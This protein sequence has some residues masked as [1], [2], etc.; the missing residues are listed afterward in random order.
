MNKHFTFDLSEDKLEKE[1]KNVDKLNQQLKNLGIEFSMKPKKGTEEI[2]LKIDVDEKKV[3]GIKNLRKGRA[4]SNKFDIKKVEQM[5]AKGMTNQ[6]IYKE[7]GIGK[8]QFYKK[9]Q[10]YKKG[11]E[12]K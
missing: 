10:E 1:K 11:D 4:K 5:K 8:S 6:Q 9:M 12:T 7:L 3:E 2:I